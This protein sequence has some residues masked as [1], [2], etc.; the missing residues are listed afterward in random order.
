MCYPHGSWRATGSVSEG[1]E[2]EKSQT[3][4]IF[5]PMQSG[6]T[7][8]ATRAASQ[9][10]TAPAW[11]PWRLFDKLLGRSSEI[12]PRNTP[13]AFPERVIQRKTPLATSEEAHPAEGGVF[14]PTATS[15]GE[16]TDSTGID[17]IDA[18]KPQQSREEE[19]MLEPVRQ[20]RQQ[21]EDLS[22]ARWDEQE[23]ARRADRARSRKSVA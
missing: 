16:T 7:L 4:R 21:C 11:I 18:P 17:D 6:F 15:S 8:T 3:G 13:G 12:R 2:L 5:L 20:R 1:T 10:P 22:D 14:K 9:N 19:T 23:A